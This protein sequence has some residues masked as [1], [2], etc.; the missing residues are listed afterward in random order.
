MSHFWH[1]PLTLAAS[2]AVAVGMLFA[3]TGGA[4]AQTVHHT[5]RAHSP[6][7]VVFSDFQMVYQLNPFQATTVF[8]TE[9]TGLTQPAGNLATFM[10]NAKFQYIMSSQPKANKTGKVYTFSLLKGMKWSNGDPITNKDYLFAWHVN[11]NNNVQGCVSTCDD[12][13]SIK[14]NKNG[15]GITVTLHA[16]EAT[17]LFNA[18][19]VGLLDH[20][21]NVKGLDGVTKNS[22]KSCLS[23]VGGCNA[24]ANA[25]EDKGNNYDNSTYVTAGPYQVNYWNSVSGIVDLTKNPNYTKSSPGGKPKIKEMK[26][27]PYGSASDLIAAAAAG[28]TDVT[29]DYS[30]LNVGDS[31]TSGTLKYYHNFTTYVAANADPELYFYNTYNQNVT[32]V[33]SSSDGTYA[34]PFYGSNGTKV[35]EALALAFNRAGIIENTF[36]V[37]SS[38]ANSLISYCAPILCTASGGGDFNDYHGITGTWDPI[39]G[40]YEPGKCPVS[41]S[42]GGDGSSNTSDQDALTLLGQA[43]YNSGN[44]LNVYLASTTKTY[45]QYE[46]A[47][48]QA[49]WQALAPWVN[50]TTYA[51]PSGTL[52]GDYADG[53]T[54]AH[55]QY[56]VGIIGFSGG[57]DPDGWNAELLSVD[58]PQIGAHSA[59]QENYACVSDPTIDSSLVN[60]ATAL[61]NTTRQ[62]DYNALQVQMNKQAYWEITA[63][64]PSIWTFDGKFHGFSMNAWVSPDTWNGEKWS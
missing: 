22:L 54:F 26:F 4:G 48:L 38:T 6:S 18:L 40:Q 58:C 30:L 46:R 37:D 20:S 52:Y 39:A 50:V 53:G 62:T 11:M 43:G 12:I 1:K 36:D 31:S 3:T 60:G 33:G 45:R 28:Q 14:L 7:L 35:R 16:A 23:S 10:P 25:Y 51:V 59:T 41:T 2:G 13:A 8:D 55:G 57:P 44:P 27:V 32:I 64:L 21:W 34:N 42:N 47:Y 5:A 15:L 24:V 61:S 29:E 63:P 19:D 56:E 17:A 9:V 49:C